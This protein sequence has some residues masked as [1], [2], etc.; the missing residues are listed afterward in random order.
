SGCGIEF[1]LVCDKDENKKDLLPIDVSFTKD[2]QEIV[3]NPEVDVLIELIGGLHPAYEIITEGIKH[4]KHVVTANKAV[5][6]EYWD[7]IFSAAN[8]Y[9]KSVY[10]EAAVA[11]GV[12]VIQALHEGLAGNKISGITGILNG[13]TN[14]ILTLMTQNKCSYETAVKKIINMG[15]A[16]SDISYDVSGYDTACKLSILSSLAYSSWVKLKDI[17]IEGIEEIEL[18][19]IYFAESFGYKI[20]LLGNSGVYKDKYFF[21]V[22]KF[23]IPNYNLFANISY[24]NNGI[25]LN[26]DYCGKIVLVGK[27]AGGFPAASA[28]ISDVISIAKEIVSAVGGRT[29][30]VEYYPTKLKTIS[31][32]ETEGCFYLRFITVDRPGV[33]AKIANILGRYKVSIASVYQKEPLVKLRRGV[34]IILLTHKTKEKNL[35]LALKKIKN[36]KVVLKK[37]IYIK[38]FPD[39]D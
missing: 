25:M 36:L 13:T 29:Q 23:L 19:D 22:R 8:K 6:S 16:E 4:G 7:K 5:L 31:I 1:K 9:N 20:K 17:Y 11:A 2:F 35:L 24:E 33:L 15:I 26:G 38:I 30:Y 27:G 18:Q 3:R 37:P 28:V 21:E 10:F 32:E 14:Y 34:P 12:P 39:R